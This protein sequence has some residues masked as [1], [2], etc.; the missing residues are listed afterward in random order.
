MY[1]K[2]GENKDLCAMY[3]MMQYQKELELPY[4]MF[5]TFN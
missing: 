4:C 3:V 5:S 1:V 2:K